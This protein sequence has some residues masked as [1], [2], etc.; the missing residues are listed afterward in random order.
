MVIKN[1]AKFVLNKLW[2]YKRA[3]YL[4]RIIY[5]H[6]VNAEHP[7]AHRPEQFRAQMQWL[8]DQGYTCPT[9]STFEKHYQSE[10]VAFITFDDGYLDNFTHAIPILN[11]FN[12]KATFF[13]CSGYINNPE[14]VSR[15]QLYD[16]LT[17]LN[18]T[19]LVEMKKQGME[20]GSHGVTHRMISRLNNGEQYQ[21]LLDSKARLQEL[22]SEQVVSFAYPQG[23]KGAVS[24]FAHRAA[25]QIGYNFICTTLWGTCHEYACV[26]KRCEMSQL[27]SLADF[28]AKMTGRRDYRK[29]VDALI[30]K[31]KVWDKLA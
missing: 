23:Q 5:Y 28:I 9:L 14:D 15:H 30:D 24:N 10:K 18:D 13:V 27:D 12:F 4:P 26:L 29:Y 8:F 16:G 1:S 11:E 6:S 7:W 21:E 22:I 17:M 3:T 31:S 19:H 20:I 2:Q 25:Q